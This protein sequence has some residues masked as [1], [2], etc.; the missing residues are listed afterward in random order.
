MLRVDL[1]L[2][3]LKSRPPKMFYVPDSIMF[4]I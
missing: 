2:C 1:K 3:I 4:P